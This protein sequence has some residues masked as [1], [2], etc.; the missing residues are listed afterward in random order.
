MIYGIILGLLF[1]GLIASVINGVCWV[2]SM[3]LVGIF[4]LVKGIVKA[5][6][7]IPGKV[8][9]LLNKRMNYDKKIAVI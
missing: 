8:M 7:S 3:L 6:I 5:V 2:C 1:G 4:Y 9:N